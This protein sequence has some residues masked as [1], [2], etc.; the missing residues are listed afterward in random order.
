MSERIAVNFGHMDAGAQSLQMTMKQIY[1]LLEKLDAD[2]APLRASWVAEG[3]S[4]AAGSYDTSRAKLQAY[5]DQMSEV[6]GRFG[7]R[8]ADASAMQRDLEGRNAG[9]FNA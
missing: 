1:G 9:M 6:I 8:T 2:V 7:Q 4:D 5:V 3:G